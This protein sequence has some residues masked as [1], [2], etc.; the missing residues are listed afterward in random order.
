MEKAVRRG[1]SQE[2]VVRQQAAGKVN[3]VVDEDTNTVGA[4][5][6]RNIFTFFNF[7]FFIIALLLFL[8]GAYRQL[9][10]LPII[11]IN[12]GMGIYQEIKAKRVLDKMNLMH[13]SHSKVIREGKEHRIPSE[14]LVLGDLIYLKA[15]DQIPADA[16]VVEGYI[17]VNEALLTGEADEV[18]KPMEAE[19]MSGSF[20]VSGR[21]YAILEKVGADSYISQLSQEAKSLNVKEQ[22]EILKSLNKVL[23]YVSLVVVPIG[24]TLFVQSFF[25]NAQDMRTSVV[26]AVSAVFGMIPEGLYLLTT[27]ALV[28]GSVTLARRQVMLHNMK[29]IESLAHVD[30][31]CVD[32]TGTI[33]QPHMS[34][35]Q[36]VLADGGAWTREAVD[37]LLASYALASPDD[38]ETMQALRRYAN[39]SV[40]D[41]VLAQPALQ[42]LPFSSAAKLGGVHFQEG[43]F[44]LGAPEFV[45]RE[46]FVDVQAD[47]QSYLGAGNRV[48]VLAYYL[49]ETL[50]LPLT[51][52]AQPLAYVVLNNPIRENAPETFAYFTKQ[53]VAITVISGDNPKTVSEVAKQAGIPQAERYVDCLELVTDADFDRAI[54]AYTVFGRVNPKQKRQLVQAF[55]RAGRTVAM[56]GDGVNDILAMKEADCSVAM[57]SGSEA[58]TQ[59]AQVVLLDNDFARL[60]DV[61]HEGRRVVNNIQRSAILF[62]NKNIFSMLL[63]VLSILFVITYPIKAAQLS[64]ISAFTIGI[65]GF[66][67][68]LEVNTRRIHK[69]FLKQVMLKALPASITSLVTVLFIAWVGD[70]FQIASEATSTASAIIM[71]IVGFFIM[72]EISR[73]LNRFKCLVILVNL[74]GIILAAFSLSK[75][76]SMSAISFDLAGLVLILSVISY[77]FYRILDWLV[78][79]VFRK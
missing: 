2:E 24:L 7:L 68:S 16:R 69:D 37:D 14:D 8:V 10:F 6:R 72:I 32:K 59:S 39:Q 13:A 76:F 28:M 21:A 15:G 58:A 18:E 78:T 73:P 71:A 55:H 50:A 9:T 4:I 1:L 47:I 3:K 65:P 19:L 5:V 33:T 23:R 11:I 42:S 79:R 48:L 31:L 57:A 36:V 77:V 43:I 25:F 20:V 52:P 56:T 74:V 49:G 45:L 27:L 61:L 54:Q 64:L 67:L 62:L 40:P 12:A 63:A 44:L 70:V 17:T 34:V 60:T 35:E 66:L 75:F 41:K 51:A 22:S 38:N 53:D 46:G 29:S 26:A 30:T